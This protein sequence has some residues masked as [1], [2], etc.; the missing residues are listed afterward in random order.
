MG[1]E[2]KEKKKK[3]FMEPDE[4][5]TVGCDQVDA[6]DGLD[7]QRPRVLAHEPVEAQEDAVQQ[8]Q[9][10]LGRAQQ[11]LLA[12]KDWGGRMGGEREGGD[13]GRGSERPLKARGK[14]AATI[15]RHWVRRARVPHPRTSSAG[16][17]TRGGEEKGGRQPSI[18]RNQ[19]SFN[20]P[21]VVMRRAP[22]AKSTEAE[23]KASANLSAPTE[24]TLRN[25]VAPPSPPAPPTLPARFLLA[26][27]TSPSYPAPLAAA[28]TTTERTLGEEHGEGLFEYTGFLR[29]QRAHGKIRRA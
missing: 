3:E 1:G 24:M 26:S 10:L 5:R 16:W 2:E 27:S 7:L 17:S 15:S 18:P 20:Q 11:Q 14:S 8:A 25:F 13:M 12:L 6:A 19:L 29:I 22:S 9:P 28:S 23:S 4:Q 21:G